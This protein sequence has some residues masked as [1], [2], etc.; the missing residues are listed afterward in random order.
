MQNKTALILFLMLIVCLISCGRSTPKTPS[1]YLHS[2]MRKA[3]EG[4]FEKAIEDY[5]KA[6]ELDPEN[7]ELYIAR[8]I[9]YNLMEEYEKSLLDYG[10]AIEIQPELQVGLLEIMADLKEKLAK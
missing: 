2:G 3:A 6:I 9:S 10:K 1:D 5:S 7:P 4:D 8:A